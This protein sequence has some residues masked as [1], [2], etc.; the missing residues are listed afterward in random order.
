MERGNNAS[1]SF[2]FLLALCLAWNDL[3]AQGL[4]RENAKFWRL[5]ENCIKLQQKMTQNW[6]NIRQWFHRKRYLLATGG[7]K[8]KRGLFPDKEGFVG[9]MRQK[10]SGQSKAKESKWVGKWRRGF[11]CPFP[12]WFFLLAVAVSIDSDSPKTIFKNQSPYFSPSYI[13]ESLFPLVEQK[14]VVWR[15]LSHL[16]EAGEEKAFS[17]SSFWGWQQIVVVDLL[18][19]K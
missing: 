14:K 7:G 12:V 19:F 1:L 11:F 2:S 8:T 18:W 17:S 3:F 9:G 16:E 13:G 5:R 15:P 4:Q 6:R 10:K